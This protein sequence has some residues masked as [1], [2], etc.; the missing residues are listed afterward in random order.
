M[1]AFLQKYNITDKSQLFS[2][3][4]KN[5][6]KTAGMLKNPIVKLDEHYIMYC[7][8]N[9][10]VILDEEAITKIAEFE[11]KTENDLVFY[12]ATNGYILSHLKFNKLLYIHQIITGYYGKG[13]GTAEL[14][15]DHL[16]RNK[17]DNRSSNLRIVSREVQEQNSNGILP[18][19]KRD[20]KKTAK[21]LPEGLTQDMMPKYIV[22]YNEQY[23]P[24]KYREF[25]KIERHS[26]LPNAIIGNKSMK[27]PLLEK[28]EMIKK[29]LDK[30]NHPENYM[31]PDTN[32]DTNTD[33]N[34][35]LPSSPIPIPVDDDEPEPEPEPEEV[36]E[37]PTPVVVD[38]QEPIATMKQKVKKPLTEKQIQQYADKSLKMKTEQ[39]H[40]YTAP[41]S[42]ET[43]KKNSISQILSGRTITDEQILQVRELLSTHSNV[44]IGKKLNLPIHQ[45]SKIRNN[46][47]VLITELETFQMPQKRTKE[48]IAIMKRKV[49]LKDVIRIFMYIIENKDYKYIMAEVVNCTIDMCK[50]MKKNMKK[51]ILPFYACEM[52][53]EEYTN[54]QTIL[55]EWNGIVVVDGDE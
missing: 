3:K 4:L 5:M 29:E 34:I 26:K 53:A 23:A 1:E 14:S 40:I 43:R 38:E 20:R 12:K 25:F 8:I 36:I 17:L 16:N 15:I 10:E 21:P 31:V 28:L 41:K 33:I 48:E 13:K 24:G 22:Y 19:T 37:E 18:G 27:I 50:N 30:I 47:L 54:Y 49:P 42:E 45:I 9:T 55:G 7:E 11:A 2:F 44:D 39:K 32:I 35:V 46:Q 52:S 6:G 51:N